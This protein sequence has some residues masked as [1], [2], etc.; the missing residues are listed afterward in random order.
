MFRLIISFLVTFLL[1]STAKTQV[2]VKA[3][4]NGV[5][6]GSSW[7]D[8]FIDL[9]AALEFSQSGDEIWVAQGVYKPGGEAPSRDTFFRF[10]HDLKLY[11]GF[12]GTETELNQRDIDAN[13]TILSGDIAG[14][15]IVS[16][17]NTNKTDN[18]RHIMFLTDVITGHSEIDGFIFTNG[19]AD[20]NT[21]ADDS[22]RGGGLL[23]YGSPMIRNCTFTQNHA[24]FGGGLYPRIGAEPIAIEN[25]EFT[26][27]AGGNGAGMYLNHDSATVT[28]CYFGGNNA[29]NNG[30][31][32]Y[33]TSENGALVQACTF[34][35][36][37]TQERRGGGAY[38]STSPSTFMNCIFQSNTAG[39]SSGGNFHVAHSEGE[40]SVETQFI[41]CLITEGVSTWGGGISVYNQGS[42]VK[43]IDCE[44]TSNMSFN[45][46][47]AFHLGFEGKATFINSDING[48]ES[49]S[50]GAFNNQ[51]DS[52]YLR[53]VDCSILNNRANNNGG[54]INFFSDDIPG[55]DP[56]LLSLE[57]CLF[58]FNTASNQGGAVNLLNGNMEMTNCIL[59][60]NINQ[61]PTGAG[62]AV[63]INGFDT[64]ATTALI[65]NSTFYGNNGS[66]GAAIGH[67]TDSTGTNILTLQNSIF[68]GSVG[69]NYAV[70]AGT[71]EVV[72]LGGNLSDDA[73]MAFDLLAENDA[74]FVDPML[75]NPAVGL[76]N[77]LEDSP[78]VD[79][80][81]DAGAPEYDAEGNPRW[82]QVDKGA[83]EYQKGA[84]SVKDLASSFDQ[85][86]IYPNPVVEVL[87]ANLQN[88]WSGEVKVAIANTQGQ[89]LESYPFIKRDKNLQVD[90][91]VNELEPG[92]YILNFNLNQKIL[93]KA[94]VKL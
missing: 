90:L 57:N 45:L 8:A 47:G 88:S 30:A 2:F 52:T 78:C 25:C 17:F 58:G 31:G 79:T 75:E 69:G 44:V 81:I 65:L 41:N 66:L 67:F 10:T 87:N 20:D 59:F 61:S 35:Q 6:D 21:G 50:G 36:N 7:T 42:D 1:F 86:K 51:D 38:L 82:D 73:T 56:P 53:L 39:N 46:G 60:N 91:N 11:G 26:A 33:I 71:P 14:D 74:I 3:D 89:I 19:H 93:S 28:D 80:G 24:W 77:L 85:I 4:A 49:A 12:N 68:S 94:F 62:G 16:D 64:I 63:S 76:F 54:A 83:L 37:I 92:Y 9:S 27:N 34:E 15:D 84:S 70:E 32:V 5:N 22:R 55:A 29:V 18:V 72:S 43:I 48:N 23:T 40:R 13:E